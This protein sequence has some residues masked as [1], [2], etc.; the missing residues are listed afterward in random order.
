[1]ITSD[2]QFAFKA[3]HSSVMC[4]SILNEIVSYNLKRKTTVYAC[5]VDA[6]KAFDR[7]KFG[8]LFGILLSTGVPCTMLRLLYRMYV[9]QR[10]KV[11]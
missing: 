9:N 5:I 11:K 2:Y 8:K 3:K 7:I 1:M 6:T 4:A 10:I